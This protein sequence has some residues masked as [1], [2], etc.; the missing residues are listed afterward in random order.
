MSDGLVFNEVL[1][2]YNCAKLLGSEYV[3]WIDYRDQI[4]NDSFCLPFAIVYDSGGKDF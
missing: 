4:A 1:R 3:S 2:Q